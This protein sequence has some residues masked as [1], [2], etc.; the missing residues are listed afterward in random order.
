VSVDGSQNTH[1]NVDLGSLSFSNHGIGWSS[2]S[3]HILFYAV[4]SSASTTP[5][6]VQIDIAGTDFEVILPW[7]QTLTTLLR[8]QMSLDGRYLAVIASD[9]L[10]AMLI[11]DLETGKRLTLDRSGDDLGFAWSPDGTQIAYN[12][13]GGILIADL[14]EDSIP[15]PIA[16]EV[17]DRQSIIGWRGD[18]QT[19][20]FTACGEMCEIFSIGPDGN[21]LEQLTND[22]G[23]KFFPAVSPISD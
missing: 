3:Q 18:G 22:G 1:L 15:R 14:S 21:G 8:P 6:I 19:L 11:F 10:N 5:G 9:A 17:L 13:D 23:L 7:T 12:S 20:L 16:D 4:S 2:D